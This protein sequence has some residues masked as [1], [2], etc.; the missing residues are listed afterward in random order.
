MQKRSVIG[1][2]LTEYGVV[3]TLVHVGLPVSIDDQ[4]GIPT[5]AAGDDVKFSSSSMKDAIDCA[6]YECN[7]ETARV[8]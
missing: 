3:Q 4:P 7:L 8:V 2:G 6:E 5:I 1:R